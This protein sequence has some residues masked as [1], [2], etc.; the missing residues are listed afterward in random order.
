MQIRWLS[1]ILMVGLSFGLAAAGVAQPPP[2]PTIGLPVTA[3]PGGEW[4]ACYT[5][6]GGVYGIP[7]S[8]AGYEQQVVERVNAERLTNG[9]LPPLKLV[10]ALTQSTRYHATDMAADNY[11]NHDTY[12]RS[13]STLVKTCA[14]S[15]RIASYYTGWQWLGENIA[16]GYATPTDVMNAWM[17][18]TAG[19]RDNILSAS[20]WELG[21]GYYQGGSY[22]YYW[23]Q[24]FGRRTGFY[25][26]VINREAATTDHYRVSLYIYGQGIWPQMR[27]RNDNNAWST[28]QTFT[29]T[30]TWDLPWSAG[31]HAV[32]AELTDGTNTHVTSDTI[33]LTRSFTPTLGG[34]PDVVTFTYSIPDRLLLPARAQ[35]TPQNTSTGDLLSW[36]IT[37]TG[38]WYTLAPTLGATPASFWITPTT[39]STA[40]VRVYTGTVTVTVTSPTT[41]SGTPKRIPLVLNVIN[42]PFYRAYLP[43]VM[44]AYSPPILPVTPND[45]AYGSQWGL[46]KINAPLAWGVSQGQGI[47]I[48]VLDSGADL[49]HPDLSGQLRSDIDWDY[50]NN[51]DTAQDDDGHGTHVAG[52]AAAATNNGIGVAGLGWNATVLPLKV[53]DNEGSG[54]FTN[55]V[56][57]LR[58][59]TDHGAKIINM[60][61]G[62]DPAYNLQC[63]NY[64][65]L[66][67]ALKY[68]YDHGVLNIVAAGNEAGNANQVMPANC[69]Y[70]LTVAATDSSDA[71]AWFSNSGTVV[72]IAAPGADIYSTYWPSPDYASMDGTSMATPFVAGLAALVWARAPA[73]TP[74]QVAAAILD[75]AR[76]LGPAGRD[77]DFGCGRID[78][79]GAV[80]TGTTRASSLCK[81]TA[82]SG[83]TL[84]AATAETPPPPPGSYVPGRLIVGLRAHDLAA[85]AD[86]LR[87]YAVEPLAQLAPGGG[88]LMSVPVGQ[89]WE[90]A[91]RLLHDGVVEYAHLDFL[92]FAQ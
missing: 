57:A 87:A 85:Q 53:L 92:L 65:D 77:N 86:T 24:D 43:L 71:R 5:G 51:D 7:S 69:P 14:W 32:W 48:A 62:S 90:I 31:E 70:V 55:L 33:R 18:S 26:L 6:C 28:W 79:P 60:S 91:Q 66:V 25:P 17:S 8:N 45:P 80:I 64:P 30:L 49:G 84:Q 68:A 41:T 21:V 63:A 46:A 40:T 19:H 44:R 58:Y 13:G 74:E 23:A 88:W 20:Y 39:F 29:S 37:S 27:L 76:D 67:N 1:L 82:L 35:L 56:T 12:D 4:G 59:A 15:A 50:V 22:G 52:I 81:P 38:T 2:P 54:S 47:L 9:N 34:L 3:T 72:D 89:E 73:Y 61:L 11:F 10:P 78:A 75:N 42:K 36:L 16:A 83:T